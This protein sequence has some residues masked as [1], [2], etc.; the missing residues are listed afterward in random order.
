MS[1]TRSSFHMLNIMSKRWDGPETTESFRYFCTKTSVALQGG[2]SHIKL[3]KSAAAL[4]QPYEFEFYN[5]SAGQHQK[6][7]S[8]WISKDGAAGPGF[9]PQ[10]LATLFH[11]ATLLSSSL[12]IPHKSSEKKR[13]IKWRDIYIETEIVCNAIICP[14]ING[15][16]H[17]R[18]AE[19][20]PHGGIEVYCILFPVQNPEIV[21]HP[22]K[23]S[24]TWCF[25]SDVK[26]V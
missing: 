20:I 9:E 14:M 7:D 6:F 16:C 21:L 4:L 22:E 2:V 18:N 17:L 25:Y 5:V 10:G 11:Y 3:R 26:Y 12:A 19:K 15:Y 1:F 24:F 8:L 23:I 13:D